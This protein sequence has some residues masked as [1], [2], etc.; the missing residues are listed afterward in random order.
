MN[1]VKFYSYLQRTRRDLWVSL[2]NLS[3]EVLSKNM[4][5]AERFRCIKDLLMHIAVVEDSWIHEDILRD[6]PVW[7]SVL[8]EALQQDGAFFADTP[9]S[10]I[11]SY[12]KA[13]EASTLVFLESLPNIDLERIVEEDRTVEGIL[14]HV[15]QHEVRHTAQVALLIRQQGFKPPALDL[16]WFLP[17]ANQ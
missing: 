2:E 3:D 4:I 13:V 14:W 15:M 6:T 9:L 8:P 7:Q 16:L 17:L 5:P 11:L 1:I 10:T 12:W